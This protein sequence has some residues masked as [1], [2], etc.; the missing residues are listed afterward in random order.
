MNQNQ[1][2][3]N[4]TKQNKNDNNQLYDQPPC[5]SEIKSDGEENV[6]RCTKNNNHDDKD[7]KFVELTFAD[8]F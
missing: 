5:S 7:I 8:D 3:T 2:S 1:N 4:Q 6:D